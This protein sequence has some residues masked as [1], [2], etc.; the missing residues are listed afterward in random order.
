M[1]GH[2]NVKFINFYLN[3]LAFLN[4]QL[5]ILTKWCHIAKG[6]NLH[7]QT[8]ENITACMTVCFSGYTKLLD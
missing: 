1:Y 8:C 5:Y 2:L 7:Q 4:G 6:W 3:I